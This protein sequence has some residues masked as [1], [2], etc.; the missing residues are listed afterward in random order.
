[1]RSD[2]RQDVVAG[3]DN[4][5]QRYT[6]LVRRV[7]RGVDHG[8]TAEGLPVARGVVD[9]QP[10]STLEVTAV[11]PRIIAPLTLG[12]RGAHKSGMLCVQ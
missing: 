6:K 9:V 2:L 4:S 3:E 8:R 10:P 7:A 5:I 11:L 1:M 12:G